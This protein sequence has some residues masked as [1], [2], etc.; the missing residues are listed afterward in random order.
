MFGSKNT[1]LTVKY[2][3]TWLAAISFGFRKIVLVSYSTNPTSPNSDR[4]PGD[5]RQ[6]G[7]GQPLRPVEPAQQ[8]V[9]ER[10]RHVE[11]HDLLE[12]GRELRRVG[13]LERVQDDVPREQPL[14]PANR[15]ARRRARPRSAPVARC[16]ASAEPGGASPAAS[17]EPGGAR[18][19]SAVTMNATAPAA[20][21]KYSGTSRFEVTP[22]ASIGIRN[23]SATITA[24][25]STDGHLAITNAGP[26]HR[27]QRDDRAHRGDQR[28]A[29]DDA[30][31]R[32]VPDVGQQQHRGEHE[33]AEH[34]QRLNARDRGGA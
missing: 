21:T 14:E 24:P 22:P 32:R 7:S 26:D 10:E 4:Q 27:R 3:W 18:P 30:E 8:A 16:A 2:A 12:R 25:A 23:G 13:R 34:R 17:A 15:A 11:E 6:A 20:T 33:R 29:V 5:E 28:M 9:R 1:E 31:L 19:R